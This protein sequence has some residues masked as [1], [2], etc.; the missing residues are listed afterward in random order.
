MV[1][2]PVTEAPSPA[3][4]LAERP[5]IRAETPAGSGALPTI[6]AASAQRPAP[7]VAADAGATSK[8]LEAKRRRRA[9]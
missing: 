2:P 1:M 6:P 3:G 5:A 8:L 9:Q 7:T 4:G